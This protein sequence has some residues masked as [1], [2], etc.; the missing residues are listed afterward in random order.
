[1]LNRR[2]LAK[3]NAQPKQ[4]N[5]SMLALIA[6]ASLIPAAAVFVLT[7]S[8]PF[9]LIALGAGAVVVLFAYRSQ[10]AKTVMALTY[11]GLE[12]ELE[13]RFTAVR[14][15][16][17]ALST[18]EM[19][20]HLKDLR[21]PGG[22]RPGAAE[23]PR[24]TRRSG[25]AAVLPPREEARVGLLETPGIRA[26]V[27]IWGIEAGKRA[28]L[29]FFPEA[30]LV[31]RDGRYEGFSY[32]S[33]SVKISSAP[34][35]EREQVPGDAKV[36]SERRARSQMPVVLYTLVEIDFPRALEVRLLVSSRRAAARF[37]KGFGVESRKSPRTEGQAWAGETRRRR[38][39]DEA[40]GSG[41]QYEVLDMKERASIA[42]AYTTLGVQKGASIGEI[43]AA[44]KRLARAHHPDKVANLPEEDREDSERQM[45][46]INAAYTELKRLRKYLADG[47]G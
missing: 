24:A 43:S 47:A 44:Y 34:Y 16:C 10:K 17:E 45:K 12:G 31:Y 23:A 21:K 4:V 18:S 35:Y 7:T 29:Y 19:I 22:Q 20:W 37:V 3:I 25:D 42:S 36:A 8:L 1:M 11:G 27:P 41:T 46:E 9:S 5:R 28:T 30:V 14:E 39:F 2:T 38:A 32:E 33:L 26:G 6:A 13:T 40:E 15:G